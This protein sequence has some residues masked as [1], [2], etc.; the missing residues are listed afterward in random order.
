MTG[1]PL[2]SC[3]ASHAGHVY[4]THSHTQTHSVQ[5]KHPLFRHLIH[6]SVFDRVNLFVA[7]ATV[8]VWVRCVCGVGDV[9]MGG[10]D[11]CVY[12]YV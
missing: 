12:M 10:G 1:K 5:W 4:S 9:C 2:L 11:V 8:C 3:V 7:I 6:T